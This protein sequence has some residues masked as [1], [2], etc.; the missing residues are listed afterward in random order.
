MDI[1]EDQQVWYFFTK[2]A[3]VKLLK[4]KKAETVNDF[5]KIVDESNC[6]AN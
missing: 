4:D 1:K 3:R 6:K 5:I 2:Y